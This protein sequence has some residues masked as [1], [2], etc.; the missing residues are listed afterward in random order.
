LNIYYYANQIYQFSNALPLYRKLGGSLLIPKMLKKYFMVKLYMKNINIFP[1]V[2]TFLNTPPILRRDRKNIYEMT[3]VILSLSNATINSDS[4]KCKTIFIGHG[5]GDKKFGSSAHILEGYDYHFISGSKHLHKLRDVG[6]NIPAEK[7]IKIGNLRFDDYV[8]NTINRDKEMERLG[9]KDR[10]RKNI[11]YAPT[12]RWGNGTIKKYAR[13]FAQEITK[14]YNLIIRPHHHDRRY[15]P[16]LM[17]W[18]KLNGIKHVYFSNPA[19]LIH[20]ETM[21]DFVVSDLMISD[22]SSILYE[23]L[24]TGNPIIVVLTDFDDLHHMPDDMNIMKHTAI[25]DGRQNINEIIADS[26]SNLD[27][28]RSEYKKILSNCFYFNDGKSVERAINFIDS[29]QFE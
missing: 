3:G 14:K 5:T 20:C 2:N 13:F 29:I 22:T 24:I 17:L 21:N 11:L 7:L 26:F 8:N 4:K 16:Q 1:E 18:A 23:Y 25:F 15:L 10:E 9:I 6:L 12:W 28:K 27:L 19:D